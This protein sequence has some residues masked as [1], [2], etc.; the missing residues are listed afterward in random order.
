MEQPER[1][2]D[3]EQRDDSGRQNN[4]PP[5]PL[6]A[7]IGLLLVLS[8]VVLV[9]LS[10][11]YR[12]EARSVIDYSVFWDQLTKNNVE[13]VV[14]KHVQITG[15]FRS[16]PANPDHLTDKTQPATL[17]DLFQ[18]EIPVVEDRRLLDELQKHNVII[19]AKLPEK[20]LLTEALVYMLP[21]FLLI[22]FMIYMMR[23][24][25]DPMGSGMLGGFIRSPAK[26][27]RP[28]DQRTTFD[29]VAGMEHAKAE[30][31]EVVEFLKDPAKFQRLGAQIPKGVLL[32]GPPGTGKTLLAR[33]CAGEAGVPFFSI[34]GSEFIQM[35]VGV[36]ASRVRD[37]FR[38]A[39]EA[40]PAIIF[41][42]EID[43]VGRVRGAGLGGG[44][45][46]REQTLNQILSEMDGFQAT[47]AV[48]VIAATNRP[49]V[50][51][52]ALLRPGRF[53]R[54]VTVDRPTKK[55]REAI[56]GVHS[57][58]IPLA[59]DVQLDKVAAGTIGFAGADL[60]NLVN[61][62]AL[63]AT[64]EGKSAVDMADFEAAQDKII[65]GVKRE[66]VLTFH[67]RRM[68]AYHEAGHALLAWL[69]PDV[70][71]VHKVTIVPRGRSLGVTHFLPQDE[72]MS[73][74]E[75]KLKAQLIVYLGGRAAEKLTFDEFT[76]GAEDDLRRATAIARRMIAYW[77]MSDVIGPAAFR[78]GEEHPF[79]GKEIHEQRQ[80]SEETAHVIDQ[81]IQRFLTEAQTSATRMLE[82]NR[83]KLT[84]LAN[85]L[86]EQEL[87]DSEE[88]AKV[89]GPAVPRSSLA[90]PSKE[91]DAVS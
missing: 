28:S 2:N 60:K 10:L 12:A 33:A 29:D 49:D 62:A 88:I 38:T 90:D 35:F 17:G 1:S 85:A 31:T 40:A 27:F 11:F 64:R 79:L 58:K 72:R 65:M 67:E 19:G 24:S 3:P 48:I 91:Q 80:F 51:D 39:K 84:T 9:I 8:L 4:L 16:K 46:E 15:K 20:G 81:E 30:L 86:L 52:P 77:G 50:L 74:G 69:L 23:R 14:I 59:P 32:N 70:D 47:E 89:I 26:R 6:L 57:R 13:Q 66:E 41:I 44:H 82:E 75:R 43:A 54:H 53:D 37:L 56:L 63:N 22:G 76:A 5:T 83:D 7:R 36:G 25:S 18:T 68:T 42:D 21:A 34:N 61:E 55:G 71:P 73:I 45:D 87:L 78:Q